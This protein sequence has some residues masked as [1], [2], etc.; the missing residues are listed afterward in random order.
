MRD[1]PPPSPAELEALIEP[2]TG[3]TTREF[4][5]RRWLPCP[6]SR[7]CCAGLASRRKLSQQILA[8]ECDA[9]VADSMNVI[10]EGLYRYGQ[11]EYPWRITRADSGEY[12]VELLLPNG[13]MWKKE[14][15]SEQQARAEL[16]TRLQE[17]TQGISAATLQLSLDREGGELTVHVEGTLRGDAR[18][19]FRQQLARILSEQDRSLVFELL[20][21]DIDDEVALTAVINLFRELLEQDRQ[22]TV[23]YCPQ[24]LAHNLY[25]AGLLVGERAILIG[26]VRKEEPHG[27]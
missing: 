21:F 27:D 5:R 2:L 23:R 14:F 1:G 9:R 17:Y 3:A 6:A 25:K 4:L 8:K 7:I 19:S 11:L 22:L 26:S 15:L 13:L 20:T 12:Q 16:Q 18:D 24:M 10:E